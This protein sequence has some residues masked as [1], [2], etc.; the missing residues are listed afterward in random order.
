MVAIMK[1]NLLSIINATGQI[2]DAPDLG[3]ILMTEVRM[4]IQVQPDE[5]ASLWTTYDLPTQHLPKLRHPV[6]AFRRAAPRN[7]TSAKHKGLMLVEYKGPAKEQYDLQMACV[8]TRST[9]RSDRIEVHHQNRT[10]LGIDKDGNVKRIDP[11]GHAPTVD[12]DAYLDAVIAQYEQLRKH[13]DGDQIR[14]AITKVLNDASAIWVHTTTYVVPQTQVQTARN[15][16]GLLRALD[17]FVPRDHAGNRVVVI[18]YQD[19]PEQRS[20]LR[21]QIQA[22]VRRE[23]EGKFVEIASAQKT[24]GKIGERAKDTMMADIG[25]LGILIA[26]YEQVL[27]ESLMPVRNYLAMQ[28]AL[29][30]Q[31][32]NSL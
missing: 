16:T 13:I 29:L 27:K 30:T 28:Q 1:T 10:V 20:Q 22:H 2:E 17:R 32:L 15:L 24:R 26:E 11:I 5:L 4:N 21:D 23:I 31:E 6:D 12:E 19:T 9:D 7:R 25:Q 18:Q 8:L 14:G 3:T